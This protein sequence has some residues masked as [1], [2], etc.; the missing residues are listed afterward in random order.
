MRPFIIILLGGALWLLL[1]DSGVEA[2]AAGVG[3]GTRNT[4]TRARGA[5]SVI[6]S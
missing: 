3:G 4:G 1:C 5:G 6:F 2:A